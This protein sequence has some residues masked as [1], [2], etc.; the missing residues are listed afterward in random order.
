[1]NSSHDNQESE[2]LSRR[3]NVVPICLAAFFNDMGSD[4]LFA[5]YPLFL[6]HVIGVGEMKILGLLDTLALLLGL[7]IMPMTGRLADRQGRKHFIWSGYGCLL[8][9]RVAQGLSTLWTHLIPAKMLYQ[10][11]RGIRNP[12]REALLIDSVPENQRGQAFGWL[13][14]A[15]TVGAIIGPILGL[16]LF[17]WFLAMNLP[18]NTTYRLI[19][20][21]SALPTT[22]SVALI[23][24]GTR[25]VRSPGRESTRIRSGRRFALTG[26]SRE[27]LVFTVISCMFSFWA[28]TEN[29]MLVSGTRVLGLRGGELWLSV[30]LY[31]FINITFAPTAFF[32]GKFSDRVGRKIPLLAGMVAIS[33]LTLGFAIVRGWW[34]VA[35]LFML[36]GMYQGLFSPS[37]KA[38]VADLA[39]AERRGEV[40]GS[41]SMLVGLAAVPGPLVFG[42][43]WDALGRETPFLLSGSFIAVCAILLALFVHEKKGD[44]QITFV[45]SSDTTQPDRLLQTSEPYDSSS[46][47]QVQKRVSTIKFIRCGTRY[48][49]ACTS[50]PT[51]TGPS[52]P[53]V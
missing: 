15:D 27:L 25:D 34:W 35:A 12:P 24:F 22:V 20:L 41:Y 19:F 43:L 28:V 26:V 53:C 1:M 2:K 38:F 23:F 13:G 4:M 17:S 44:R 29:F 16:G 40:L 37:Q 46:P 31:W 33:V 45:C 30:L 6:I 50:G 18:L 5:F 10:A 21:C 32:A 48:I 36:H 3:P 8:I 9:S 49:G 42:F 52:T 39:P 14:S 7:V 11:G 51:T 47:Q